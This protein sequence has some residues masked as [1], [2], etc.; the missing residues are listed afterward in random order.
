LSSKESKNYWLREKF[1][2]VIKQPGLVS[3]WAVCLAIMGK[4][5]GQYILRTLDPSR[6]ANVQDAPLTAFL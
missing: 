4:N 3:G 1:I 2:S 5:D 6:K